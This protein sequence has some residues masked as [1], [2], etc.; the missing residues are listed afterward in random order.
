MARAYFPLLLLI[1]FVVAN[2][3]MMIAVSHLVIRRRPT[4]VKQMPYESG[5][6]VLGDARERFSVKFYMVAISFI[7]FDVET[8][9]LVPWAAQFKRL[10]CL[11][12]LQNG[13]CPAGQTTVAPFMAMLVFVVVLTVGIIYEW[14]KGALQWD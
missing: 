7:I 12:P 10:S 3:V 1:G 6:P 9:L 11:A 5:I 4:A 14:K 2:A 13:G 8:V